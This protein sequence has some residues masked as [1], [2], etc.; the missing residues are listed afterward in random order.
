M[1]TQYKIR[2][3][4]KVTP[5][6]ETT[7][8]DGTG[9]VT[10]VNS[11]IDTTYS[12]YIEKTIGSDTESYRKAE[13]TLDNTGGRSL[14]YLFKESNNGDA[15]EWATAIGSFLYVKIKS[16]AGTPT[17]T[18]YFNAGPDIL[19]GTDAVETQMKLSG[20][21]DFLAIPLNSLDLMQD[22]LGDTVYIP[23]L[24]CGAGE[25]TVVEIM[26]AGSFTIAS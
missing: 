25:S 19:V 14:R 24:N 6:E 5:V 13:V 16:G 21:G 4:G 17:C 10:A 1:A 8:A 23:R 15:E 9:A 3:S 2:N 12:A 11:N 26:V 7:L 20:V 22:E 18:I